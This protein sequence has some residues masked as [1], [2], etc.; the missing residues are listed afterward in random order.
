M[1]KDSKQEEE[2]KSFV[3]NNQYIKYNTDYLFYDREDLID[4]NEDL[5]CPICLFILKN[6]VNCS[7]RQNSHSFC[8]DCI[9][10]YF[11]ENN[12]CPICKNIF[13]YKINNDIKKSLDK[14]VFKC[15]FKTEGCNHIMPY[16]EYLNHIKE[17]KYNNIKYECQIKKYNYKKKNLKNVLILEIKKK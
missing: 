16:S 14:L 6:P 8:E 2:K 12:T 7:D 15:K 9:G 3:D 13:E 4:N 17:C 1:E 10:K 11:L 5:I